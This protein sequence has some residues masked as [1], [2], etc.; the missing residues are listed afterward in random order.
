MN[1]VTWVNSSKAMSEPVSWRTPAMQCAAYAP[2]ARA[3]DHSR[4]WNQCGDA[5]SA[6]VAEHA[7]PAAYTPAADVCMSASTSRPP[8][9]ARRTSG[10]A[11]STAGATPTA[12]TTRSTP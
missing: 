5:S 3:W 12:A 2:V 8:S 10:G 6:Q 4:I 9:G 1:R 7:S 11:Q